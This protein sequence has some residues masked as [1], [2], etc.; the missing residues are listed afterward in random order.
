MK[1]KNAN[2]SDYNLNEK[3]DCYLFYGNNTKK[4]KINSLKQS[5]CQLKE[6][7]LNESKSG[8]DEKK[9]IKPM[10]KIQ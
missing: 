2:G 10:F 4:R 7:K 8:T 3:E 9:G 6:I 5:S 1:I